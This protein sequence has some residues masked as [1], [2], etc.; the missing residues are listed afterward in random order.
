MFSSANGV[1]DHNQCKLL[2]REKTIQVSNDIANLQGFHPKVT[3]LK[4]P[5]ANV[6]ADV[7]KHDIKEAICSLLAEEDLWRKEKTDIPEPNQAP[8]RWDE[9][10][11]IPD[12]H[13]LD[14]I[15]SARRHSQAHHEMIQDPIHELKVGLVLFQDATHVDFHGRIESEPCSFTLDLFTT[16]TRE[17]PKSGNARNHL[18]LNPFRCPRSLSALRTVCRFCTMS[19]TCHPPRHNFFWK[20]HVLARNSQVDANEIERVHRR[21]PCQ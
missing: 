11:Q 16:E 8:L 21:L 20:W 15:S 2:N 4:L 19:L 9:H 7:V 6:S 17:N 10:S 5:N 14:Q 12:G 1:F 3:R 13:I 18:F